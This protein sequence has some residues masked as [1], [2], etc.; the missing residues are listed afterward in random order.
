MLSILHKNKFDNVLNLSSTDDSN[1]PRRKIIQNANLFCLL[2]LYNDQ[3]NINKRNLR[4]LN[5][6]KLQR[7]TFIQEEIP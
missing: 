7:I 3:L 5:V 1:F 6:L 4:D 2:V